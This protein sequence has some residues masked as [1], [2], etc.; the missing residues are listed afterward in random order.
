MSALTPARLSCSCYP[1]QVVNDP[2]ANA[3]G[4]IEFCLASTE[5]AQRV[6]AVGPLV[7][8]DVVAAR[9]HRH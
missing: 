2:A 4:S 5:V 8:E 6:F 3:A 9:Q 7:G 1:S